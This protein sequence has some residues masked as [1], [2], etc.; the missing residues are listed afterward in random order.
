MLQGWKKYL[1]H[2]K[3][4]GDGGGGGVRWGRISASVFFL[5][6]LSLAFVCF[7][8]FYS[9]D[10]GWSAATAN[11][12]LGPAAEAPAAV[13]D[14]S[15]TNLS[16][17]VFG[18]GG[19][20]RTWS[21]RRG[22]NELWWRPGVTRG[23]VWLDEAPPEGAWPA[24]SPPYRVSAN[25]SRFRERASAS[26]IARIVAESQRLHAGDAGVRWF[27]MG[28]D[29]TVFFVDNL[30]ATLGKYDHEE[31]YYVGAPS[32][33]VEQDVMHSYGM[34]FGGGGFAVSAP[35]AAELARALDGCL[36][37][38]AQFYGSDQ[39]LDLRGDAYG[40]L[41]A[42]PVAPLVSLHH[43]DYLAP[44]TP[45]GGD[46]LGALRTLMDAA[47]LD[48][49][50]IL[51]QCFCYEVQRGFAWSVSVSWGYTVQLYPRVLA[52]N[53][54]EVPL[55]T[56]KTWRSFGDGPFTFKTR[57]VAPDRPCDRPLLY[58]LSSVKKNG[59]DGSGS[60]MSEYSRYR[61]EEDGRCKGL[62]GYGAA[63]KVE[64]VKVFAP[65]MD[66]AAWR[67]VRTEK[68][69]LPNASVMVEP[70]LGSTNKKLSPG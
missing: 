12:G 34:A 46:R 8:A 57:Q 38:Y 6:L 66:P 7:S 47:R 21:R 29:D 36:D 53:D 28:D 55:R 31:M 65:K 39:R 50:R 44:I 23:H 64:T 40:L 58:F 51:Q 22:Y 14:P 33:S 5:V 27:V 60:T 15:P 70:Y 45:R 69:V 63:L 25:A 49:A 3:E 56:F 1:F 37:R 52:A 68:A 54:M 48:P 41:A 61:E 11:I 62:P 18:I 16:H 10:Y 19:S 26:R 2:S 17:I 13:A 32:E 43:L 20:A 9:G 42:H 35:A 67:R 59:Q 24:T 4:G 30:V